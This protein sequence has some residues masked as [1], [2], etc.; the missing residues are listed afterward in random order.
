MGYQNHTFPLA[1]Y[2][3]IDTASRKL[4]FLKVWPSNSKPEQVGRWYFD[5]LYESRRLP[6]FVRIDKGTETGV[7]ATIHAYLCSKQV[8]VENEQ[9]AC[10]RVRYGPSTSNQV[11]NGKLTFILKLQILCV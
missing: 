3:C 11:R 7:L 8:D 5:Y 6:H 1:I 4:M 9:E 2:G 10:D